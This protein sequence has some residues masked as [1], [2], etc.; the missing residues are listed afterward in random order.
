[1]TNR[2]HIDA[3][4]GVVEIEGE[5]DFVEGL[6]AKLFPLL[7]EAGF[8]SRPPN[9]NTEQSGNPDATDSDAEATE[10]G[11]SA[12]PK[13]KRRRG[14]APPKG[15]SCADRILTLKDAGFFKEH[16]SVA[17]IVGGLK[18]KGWSHN[19]NQVGAALTAM[20]K[21]GDIQRT[22]EGDSAWMYYWDRG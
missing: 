18:V 13:I 15:Q 16:R 17:D 22:K 7:E 6:L 12:K 3:P 8:G 9:C 14:S 4:A 10:P 20:F 5:K 1:V 21:R 2:V 11:D 19:G